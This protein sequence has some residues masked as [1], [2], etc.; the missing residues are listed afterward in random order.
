MDFMLLSDSS[1]L[2]SLSTTIWI[3]VCVLACFNLVLGFPLSGLIVPGFLVPLSMAHPLTG[4]LIVLEASLTWALVAG[5]AWLFPKFQ[6]GSKFFGRDRFFAILLASILVRLLVEGVFVELILTQLRSPHLSSELQSQATS[7]G[8]ILVPLMAN[9]FWKPGIARGLASLTMTCLT[10]Y[11]IIRYLLIPWTSFNFPS[12]MVNFQLASQFLPDSPKSYIILMCTV[13]IASRLNINYGWDFSGIIFP[14]LI[15]LSIFDPLSMLMTVVETM[16]I[17]AI[18]KML[19]YIPQLRA[20]SL[21][22]AYSILFFFNIAFAYKI[23]LGGSLASIFPETAAGDYLGLG[24]VMS[25]MF[26]I[27][28]C[29][30]KFYVW[31]LGPSLFITA[32]AGL[33]VGLVVSLI[34]K[35]MQMAPILADNRQTKSGHPEVQKTDKAAIWPSEE[36]QIPIKA[37]SLRQLVNQRLSFNP[38]WIAPAGSNLYQAPKNGELESFRRNLIQPLLELSN[39][40]SLLSNDGVSTWLREKSVLSRMHIIQAQAKSFGYSLLIA[41]SELGSTKLVLAESK[42][43]YDQRHWG[44]LAIRLGKAEELGVVVSRPYFGSHQLEFGLW[45]YSE[46]EGRIFLSATAHPLAND[47]GS[48]RIESFR[49]QT[50]P[51]QAKL[52]EIARSKPE[53]NFFEVDSYSD[54]SKGDSNHQISINPN[55]G[56]NN[57]N[58]SGFIKQRL[59]KFHIPLAYSSIRS[60]NYTLNKTL[61][62]VGKRLYSLSTCETLLSQLPPLGRGS[63]W[64]RVTGSVGVEKHY[65]HVKAWQIVHGLHFIKNRSEHVLESLQDFIESHDPLALLQAKRFD[66][67]LEINLVED[68]VSGEQYLGLIRPNHKITDLIPLTGFESLNIPRFEPGHHSAQSQVENVGTSTK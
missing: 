12:M 39:S 53:L 63:T 66:P 25:T 55:L 21:E 47:D 3:G 24:Y 46:F 29:R 16:I 41:Q 42:D 1:L 50:N 22:G 32:T 68:L 6:I 40:T 49:Q 15:A 10:S 62:L 52:L 64:D 17:V 45:A 58:L 20:R 30:Q 34:L 59:N 57:I 33:M 37:V 11:L 54:Y 19:L 56:A 44:L 26:A 38:N 9:Q 23:F 4:A 5:L 27:K 60:P 2:Y 65:Y 28:I 48:S 31:S 18:A 61:A 8:L 43:S 7:F 36:L 13:F 51:L 35:E 14:G 67:S